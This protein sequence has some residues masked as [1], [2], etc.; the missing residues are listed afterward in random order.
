MAETYCGKSCGECEQ[1]EK[2]NCRGCKNGPGMQIGGDCELA[3]CCRMKGHETCATCGFSGTCGMLRGREGIPEDRQR[4]TEREAARKAAVAGRAPVLG[5]WLWVL[6]W[7]FIPATVGAFLSNENVV[8]LLPGLYYPGMLL[9]GG[10]SLVYAGILLAVSPVEERYRGAG[11]CM[12]ISSAA[13]L[14][15]AVISG[16]TE[17]VGMLF[18][19]IPAGIVA[20]VGECKEYTAHSYALLDADSVLGEKWSDLRKWYIGAF[21]CILGGVVLTFVVPVLGL[22]VTLAASITLVVVSIT[23]LVYLYRTADVF[24]RYAGL[25]AEED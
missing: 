11:I 23:K 9:S 1:R 20:I 14:L 7:L 6:F 5:K 2:Q 19:T 25:R 13:N 15:T 22:I 4:R 12:L 18:L 17:M 24:R 16:G 10:C 21:C 3:R 8:S